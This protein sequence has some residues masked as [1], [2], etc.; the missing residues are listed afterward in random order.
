M[1]QHFPY[2]FTLQDTEVNGSLTRRVWICYLYLKILEV[3]APFREHLLLCGRDICRDRPTPLNRDCGGVLP[4]RSGRLAEEGE[5]G[6]GLGSYPGKH[7]Q[8][9]DPGV[10]GWGEE[11]GEEFCAPRNLSGCSENPEF[12][13]RSPAF[14]RSFRLQARP[15]RRRDPRLR[16]PLRCPQTRQ[17]DRGGRSSWRRRRGDIRLGG[18]EEVGSPPSWGWTGWS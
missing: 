16:R 9:E 5:W 7:R 1:T 13:T 10:C 8:G 2:S 6:P 15:F 11:E 3:L 17:G 12:D 4:Y 14:R 18:G